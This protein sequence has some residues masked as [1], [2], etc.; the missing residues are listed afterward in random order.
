MVDTIKLDS[1]IGATSPVSDGYATAWDNHGNKWSGRTLVCI[2]KEP[3]RLGLID[4]ANL[5]DTISGLRLNSD[6][7]LNFGNE[8]PMYPWQESPLQEMCRGLNPPA[9]RSPA[10]SGSR[11]KT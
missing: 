9:Y 11:Q 10:P 6:V 1:W 8:M 2:G 3:V 5:T 4:W 7:Q